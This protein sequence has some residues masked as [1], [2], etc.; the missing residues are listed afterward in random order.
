MANYIALYGAYER[1]NF[2]DILFMH[3]NARLLSPWP[4]VPLGLVS[5]DMTRE[6]GAHVVSAS[7]WFDLCGEFLPHALIMV[8]GETLTCDLDSAVAFT[9]T[10]QHAR[11]YAT[12][13]HED[14][15]SFAKS[16]SWRS[17]T[18]PYVDYSGFC[19]GTPRT[20]FKVAYNSVGGTQLGPKNNLDNLVN[21]KSC[22]AEA[23][24]VSVRDEA[25]RSHLDKYLKIDS[26]VF[27]D[28]VNVL[29]EC[30]LDLVDG[31]RA[32]LDERIRALHGSY[33]LFQASEKYLNNH[34][35]REIASQIR[36]SAKDLQCGVVLQPAGL[37]YEHDTIESLE[38]LRYALIDEGMGE[39]AVILQTDRSVWVQVAAIAEA[40]CFI[41]TSLH[42]RIV[43]SSFA[44]PRVSLENNKVTAYAQTWDGN[45]QPYDVSIALLADAVINATRTNPNILAAHAAEITRRVQ[46]GYRNLRVSLS[47]G[48]SVSDV[49][50]TER[51]IAQLM[52]AALHKENQLL[53]NSAAD[54]AYKLAQNT[55]SL[56]DAE[57]AMGSIKKSWSWRITSPLRLAKRVLC[58]AC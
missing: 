7:A 17:G 16:V 12:L 13:C 44:R 54:M 25:T 6:S 37:A 41:G 53:R 58:K 30:C 34:P 3:V 8:G 46:D 51:R 42:G 29:P 47:I 14:K 56:L 49:A 50:E 10:S 1:D 2:G 24:Y 9:V 28:V 19:M 20:P 38:R 55:R 23:D 15:L 22:L 40:R 48:A 57:Y 21:A 31:G 43:A 33:L 39:E 18:L 52:Q 27:P 5:A 4:I 32:K 26:P 45:I 36:R 35:S 11:A